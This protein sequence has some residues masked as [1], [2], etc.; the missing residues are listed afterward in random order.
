M[1]C[2]V[3]SGHLLVWLA[4]AFCGHKAVVAYVQQVAENG[5]II[6]IAFAQQQLVIVAPLA[7][8]SILYL[9]IPYKR[10]EALQG[11]NAVA[12]PGNETLLG[13]RSLVYLCSLELDVNSVTTGCA[14][15][16]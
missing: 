14:M 4:V 8:R 13:L 16:G 11:L 12:T 3:L 9:D 10:A 1:P 15:L 6:D 2:D 7:L 5:L